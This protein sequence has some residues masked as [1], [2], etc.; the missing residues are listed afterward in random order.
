MDLD[1]VEICRLDSKG[2]PGELYIPDGNWV[3]RQA[4]PCHRS[5]LHVHQA[6]GI[7]N[8]DHMDL[9]CM[10]ERYVEARLL[11]TLRE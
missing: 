8:S 6:R 2:I 11:H 10:D 9:V 4:F 7:P 1:N 3:V 5:T